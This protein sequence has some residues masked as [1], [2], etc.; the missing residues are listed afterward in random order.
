M[1][2]ASCVKVVMMCLP[3]FILSDTI[4]R[5]LFARIP[6]ARRLDLWDGVGFPQDALD[7]AP[8]VAGP[9]WPNGKIDRPRT[10]NGAIIGRL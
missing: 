1:E 3:L 10:R 5:H 6:F 7:G 2:T 4:P 8:G 9:S